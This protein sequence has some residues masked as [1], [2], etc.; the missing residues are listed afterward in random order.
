MRIAIQ[1]IVEIDDYPLLL[2]VI[3]L[4]LSYMPPEIVPELLDDVETYLILVKF[5]F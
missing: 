4:L 2:P 3:N 1:T 5:A